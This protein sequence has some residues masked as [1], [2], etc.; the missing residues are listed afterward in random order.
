[1]TST[2]DVKRR[3]LTRSG[4]ARGILPGRHGSW[5]VSLSMKQEVGAA[6][7]TGFK[8]QLTDSV[9][10]AYRI[11]RF[12]EVK[13]VYSKPSGRSHSG[14]RTLAAIAFVKTRDREQR[15]RLLRGVVRKARSFRVTEEKPSAPA[16][17]SAKALRPPSIAAPLYDNGTALPYGAVSVRRSRPWSPRTPGN[18]ADPALD[19]TMGRPVAG[20]PIVQ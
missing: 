16:L 10:V 15:V 14:L 6:R 7:Q 18:Q 19:K 13:A 12:A 9:F 17:V 2:S 3:H 1:M 4:Y 11:D 5:A 20:R 8:S